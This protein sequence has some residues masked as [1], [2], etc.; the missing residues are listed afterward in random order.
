[1]AWEMIRLKFPHNAMLLGL[2]DK[3]WKDHVRFLLGDKVWGKRVRTSEGKSYYPAWGQ[4]LELEYQIRHR[5]FKRASQRKTSIKQALI[6]ARSD[7]KLLQGHFYGPLS[8]EAGAAAAREVLASAASSHST[9]AIAG[10][11]TIYFPGLGGHR[12][13]TIQE[14]QGHKDKGR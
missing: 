2:D 9:P 6:D 8:L 3:V 1:M 11:S 12:R 7:D 14:D 5:A 4:V 13:A 10:Q